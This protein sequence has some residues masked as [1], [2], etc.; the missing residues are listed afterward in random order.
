MPSQIRK[1]NSS[2]E[3]C[4]SGAS[5]VSTRSIIRAHAEKMKRRAVYRKLRTV[6]MKKNAYFLISF[7]RR[8][9]RTNLERS[10]KPLYKYAPFWFNATQPLQIN[11]LNSFKRA[12]L[13]R[14]I[15][16]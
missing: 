4:R 1:M 11:H 3:T 9:K 5:H 10:R 15:R 6:Y 14:G 16:S 12:G 2:T 7:I 13:R 8:T